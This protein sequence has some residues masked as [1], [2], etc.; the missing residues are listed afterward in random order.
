VR[1]FWLLWSAA[2]VL[3]SVCSVLDYS[4]TR[5]R[6]KVRGSYT[7]R[8][9]RCV[10]YTDRKKKCGGA[11]VSCPMWYRI[12]YFGYILF[13]QSLGLVLKVLMWI[14]TRLPT[15]FWKQATFLPLLVVKGLIC[16]VCYS[17]AQ[18]YLLLVRASGSLG[19]SLNENTQ[20]WSW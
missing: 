13:S 2:G 1:E 15:G 14:I 18:K 11:E 9:G 12:D 3:S 5:N 4:L 8:C 17:A 20:T 7:G 6:R 19:P 16:W 10:V